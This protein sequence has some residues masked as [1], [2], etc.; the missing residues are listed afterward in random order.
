MSRNPPSTGMTTPVTNL[1]SSLARY[2]AAQ[3]MSHPSPSNGNG[4]EDSR[5]SRIC[6]A[7]CAT[8]GVH[9]RPGHDA[10]G[11]DVVSGV[12]KRHSLG[13][14][15]DR[16]VVDGVKSLSLIASLTIVTI[17]SMSKGQRRKQ[18]PRMEGGANT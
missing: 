15:N 4:V 5:V 16:G 17:L 10:I 6:D 7:P 11:S 13:Q 2:T 1:A 14:T 12:I 3:A 9:M 8:L 18:Y